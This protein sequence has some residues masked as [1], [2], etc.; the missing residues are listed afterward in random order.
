MQ[1]EGAYDSRVC[2]AAIA[3]M[4]ES[5]LGHSIVSV[6]AMPED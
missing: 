6:P 4:V 3:A 1:G 2:H 5:T